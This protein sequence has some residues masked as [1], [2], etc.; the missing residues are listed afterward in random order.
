MLS[1]L[2][3]MLNVFD[4]NYQLHYNESY[5]GT[6]H[7]ETT[8]QGYQY[9]SSLQ[10]IFKSMLS[11]DCKNCMGAFLSLFIVK[12]TWDLKYLILMQEIYMV[13]DILKV[14]VCFKKYHH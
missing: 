9:C 13:E 8:I 1:E 14:L 5:I 6:V 3:T 7:Q 10:R 11:E 2:P 12:V 4:A